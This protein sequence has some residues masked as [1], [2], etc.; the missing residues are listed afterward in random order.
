MIR[1][2][3]F[4]APVS[5]NTVHREA[6][7]G[8]LQLPGRRSVQ[9]CVAGRALRLG[10]SPR[11][12][13]FAAIDLLGRPG[14]GRLR[15]SSRTPGFTQAPSSTTWSVELDLVAAIDLYSNFISCTFV[16]RRVDRNS[17]GL[18]QAGG[19]ALPGLA[20]ARLAVATSFSDLLHQVTMCLWAEDRPRHDLLPLEL[21]GPVS[22]S[23]KPPCPPCH[24]D[25]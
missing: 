23:W 21:L 1:R 25:G 5:A 7:P 14:V 3:G 4:M 24:H 17:A 16:P 12:L 18:G 13:T 20:M 11:W 22:R 19:L 6:L 2:S 15:V 10:G 9:V 8:Q